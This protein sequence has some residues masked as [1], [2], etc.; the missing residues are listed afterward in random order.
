MREVGLDEMKRPLIF[1]ALILPVFA[2]DCNAQNENSTNS[3]ENSSIA[4]EEFDEWSESKSDS[5][6]A[7]EKPH[8]DHNENAPTEEI[9]PV[10]QPPPEP[11]KSEQTTSFADSNFIIPILIATIV[12]LSI[13]VFIL[14]SRLRKSN[15]GETTLSTRTSKSLLRVGSINNIGKRK[16]QQDSL[17]VADIHDK[18]TLRSRGML[19]V[20]ADGMGGMK[21]GAAIGK[22]VTTAFAEK[23]AGQ[24]ISEPAAFLLDAA[25]E[26]ETSVEKYIAETNETGGSTVVAILIKD[27]NLHF[28]SIGDST[29]YLLRNNELHQLNREHNFGAVLQ[30]KAARGE[31]DPD[32]PYKNPRRNALMAYIGMGSLNLF[33]RNEQPLG[34]TN[35]D[36]VILCSDG[37]LDALGQDGLKAALNGDAETSVKHVEEA[38]SARDLPQQDNFTCVVLDYASNEE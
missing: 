17:F 34:L 16:E 37:V 18:Q 27:S 7:I 5:S 22:L 29:L 28:I 10:V 38:V 8:S 3:A 35:G 11:S 30:E 15:R 23:Y 24:S 26:A 32:E 36:K 9:P 4:S 12:C 20:I 14:F 31:V 2:A 19:A 1:L 33:D 13:A 21:G 6:D 25:R